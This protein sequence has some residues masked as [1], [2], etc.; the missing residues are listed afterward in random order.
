[1]QAPLLSEYILLRRLWLVFAQWVTVAVAVV[2]ALQT[3]RP[4]WLTG[5]PGHG[6]VVLNTASTQAAGSGSASARTDSYA[7]AVRKAQPSVVNIYTRKAARRSPLSEDP[8]FGQFFGTPGPQQN[9]GSG[10]IVSPQGYIL[11]N[12]HVVDGADEVEVAFADGRQ[13]AAKVVGADPET[14]LAVLKI[15]ANG[16]PAITLGQ[17]E[18]MHVGDVVLAIG[19]PFGVGQTVTMGIVSALG[20]HDLG[21]NTFENFIQTDAA[22]NPGNSGGALVDTRGNLIG[23]NS[24]IYSRT[25][26]S[27]GIGFAIPVSTA[28]QVMEQL[29]KDGVVTRGWLGVGMH[30]V[31]PEIAES[32]GLKTPAGVLISAIYQGG[33]ADRGGVK[34]GDIVLQLDEQSVNDEKSL[35]NR[36]ASLKPGTS[37]TLLVRRN[38]KDVALKVTIG[39]RPPVNRQPE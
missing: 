39:K 25:G 2:F 1:M 8:F 27:I 4:E 35:L 29:I 13:T 23:V 26:S 32:F 6:T 33:P 18:E 5:L 24:A 31:T 30:E 16:L 19:N 11:T 7:E 15:E 34:P 12:N 14:D 38:G 28:R 36:V 20:R 21:I 37:G 3:L 9:L 10:V 22:I 17:T